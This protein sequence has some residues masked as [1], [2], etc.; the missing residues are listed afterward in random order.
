MASAESAVRDDSVARLLAD[1]FTRVHRER[2][3]GLPILHPGLSVAVVGG[4]AW[5]GDWLGVLVTPW[6]MN[7]VLVPGP[8]SN[9]RPG[10]F[11]SKLQLELPAGGFEFLA[12]EEAGIGRFAACSL[13]SPMH[14][15]AD[16]AAAIATAEA[17]ITA[18][19]QPQ[20]PGEAAQ[21]TGRQHGV[22]RRDLLRGT[23]G[24]R[25]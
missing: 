20:P 17:I 14:Q 5:Q 16:Q 9:N 3:A 13:I 6:C 24:R 11:G 1:S 25:A 8:G 23:F 2:M 15:I 4:R 22:S 12:S 10:P 21:D 7:L 19:F 18:L